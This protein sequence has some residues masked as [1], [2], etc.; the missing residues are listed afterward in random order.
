MILWLPSLTVWFA[1][2]RTGFVS[3]LETLQ[4]DL[5]YSLLSEFG[6]ER[7][8]V[9]FISICHNW[10]LDAGG[11]VSLLALD[12]TILLASHVLGISIRFYFLA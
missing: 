11:F 3:L 4:L 1:N 7:Q 5:L 9:A 12:W 8:S 6:F 2:T 10:Q